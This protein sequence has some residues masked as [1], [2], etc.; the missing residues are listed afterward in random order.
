[1]AEALQLQQDMRDFSHSFSV[2]IASVLQRTPLTIRPR[3]VKVD[4]D[5]EESDSCEANLPSPLQPLPVGSSN[6]PMTDVT[7]SPPPPPM[8]PS[9][10]KPQLVG[11][12]VA[13]A[14]TDCDVGS[15][16]SS[17]CVGVT[18]ETVEMVEVRGVTGAEGMEEKMDMAESSKGVEPAAVAGDQGSFAGE[19]VPGL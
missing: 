18:S 12:K 6:A 8:L 11:A 14:M 19:A 1:M 7:A 2:E 5:A 16:Q 10:M 15:G 3:K 17:E 13:P 4:L 9:P